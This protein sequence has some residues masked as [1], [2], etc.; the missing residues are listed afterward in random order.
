MLQLGEKIKRRNWALA[1]GLNGAL[2]MTTLLTAM[3]LA[4]PLPAYGQSGPYYLII[5][6]RV[7]NERDSGEML[8]PVILTTPQGETLEG[9]TDAEGYFTLSG[10]VEADAGTLEVRTPG[11]TTSLGQM[12]VIWAAGGPGEK[13]LV[14]DLITDGDKLWSDATEP[15]YPAPL[16]GEEAPPA[17]PVPPP[18]AITAVALSTATPTVPAVD[19]PASPPAEKPA[20]TGGNG[21]LAALMVVVIGL[22][23]A[24]LLL[25]GGLML[26]RRNSR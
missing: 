6:G 15:P 1:V 24:A 7:T 3:W 25:G 18:T 2:A 21:W 12:N 9:K 19:T 14:I 20:G 8:K 17:T 10:S 16:P 13:R 4:R 5:E 22:V 23:A 26:L 11:G